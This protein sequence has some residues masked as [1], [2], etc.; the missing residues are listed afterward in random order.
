MTYLPI[1][2]KVLDL[3]PLCA[4]LLFLGLFYRP[5]L[6]NLR[7]LYYCAYAEQMQCWIRVR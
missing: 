5:H 7:M 6:F 2:F 1:D 4:T 3:A